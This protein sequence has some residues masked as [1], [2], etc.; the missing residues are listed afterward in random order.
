MECAF[1]LYSEFVRCTTVFMCVVRVF[2]RLEKAFAKFLEESAD[3]THIYTLLIA[4]ERVGHLNED[5]GALQAEDNAC[6]IV[7]ALLALLR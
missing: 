4:A 5:L 2:G 7:V 1:N 6:A 3:F